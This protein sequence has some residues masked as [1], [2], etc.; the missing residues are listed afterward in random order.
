MNQWD[1]RFRSEQYLYGEE[2]NVFVKEQ[3]KNGSGKVGCFAEGEGRNAVYLARLGYDVT[4]YDYSIEGL[5]K[6]EQLATKYGVNIT[7]NLKDLTI[8]NAVA[9]NQ[10]D[11]AVLVFGHVNEKYQSIFFSNLIQSVK[12]GGYIVF[13][14][15]SKAQIEYK[16]GG[17]GDLSMLYD[18]EDVKAYCNENDVKIIDLAEREVFRHEG[19]KHYGKSSVIQGVIRK[20]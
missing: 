19:D 4:A 17:P 5:K 15:Y 16:T 11:A 12:P 3:F 14:V 9:P 13:E 10:F 18:L 6:A 1:D 8:R 2:V 20:C 7:T